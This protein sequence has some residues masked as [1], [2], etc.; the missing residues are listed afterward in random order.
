M[1]NKKFLG[2]ASSLLLS[3]TVLV[4]CGNHDPLNDGGS[5]DRQQIIIGSANFPESQIISE[6][7]AQVLEDAGYQVERKPNIGARDVYLSALEDGAIDLVPEYT[8]N[9]TEFYQT[10]E[11]APET[12]DIK[13]GSTSED[14]FKL[15]QSVLPAN[16][17]AGKQAQAESKDSY[18]VTPEVAKQH[19]LTTLADLRTLAKSQDIKIGANPELKPRPYGPDGL[20]TAYGVPKD[21]IKFRAISDS[22]GPLTVEALLDGTIDVADVY[23]TSPAMDKGGREAK[24]VEL[25]DP[26]HL[27][28]PQ[29]VVPLLRSNAVDEGAR[30]AI[31]K[32]QEKL[33]TG[34][35][36]GMN[37]R[38]S[39]EEKAE[40][41]VIAKDWLQDNDLVG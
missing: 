33:T 29:N 10:A 27:I 41:D 14:I 34:A 5:S 15:L 30:Q 22:G 3:A 16:V 35:L 8:G 21:R 17:A 37:R 19:K 40:P 24:L 23:T 13:P 9:A 18:R 25:D 12:A 1:M 4:A 32:V 38:N 28:Q 36:L 11:G 26:E 2:V 6:L 39:N 20:A 7:Y 31:A